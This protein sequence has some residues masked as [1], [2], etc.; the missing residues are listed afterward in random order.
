MT[1]VLRIPEDLARTVEKWFGEAGRDWLAA[2]PA[3]VDALAARWG[4]RLGAPYGGGTHALV[5]PALGADGRPAALKIP[6]IDDENREEGEALRAYDGDG[7]VRLHAHDPETSALLLERAD[8]GNALVDEPDRDAALDVLFGLL[9]RLRRPG[10]TRV[11]FQRATELA[12]RWARRLREAPDTDGLAEAAAQR[13]AAFAASPAGPEL[14]INRDAHLG[15]V[16]RCQREP[17]LLIDPKP[18]VGEAAFEAGFPVLKLL[19]EHPTPARAKLAI[20]RLAIGLEVD[21]ER[22][23]GWALIRAMENAAWSADLGC[24]PSAHLAQAAAIAAVGG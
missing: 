12:A 4:L 7:A 18:I 19:G 16:L 11:P 9:R 24:D 23:Q 20:G 3:T 21:R 8:P 17:W 6:F 14:L 5:L 2:L 1:P 10:P 22:V 13:A 15:N